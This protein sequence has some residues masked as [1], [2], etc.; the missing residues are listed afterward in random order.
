MTLYLKETYMIIW[1]KFFALIVSFALLLRVVLLIYRSSALSFL[2][3]KQ[4]GTETLKLS[5]MRYKLNS[6]TSE[7]NKLRICHE[8]ITSLENMLVLTTL[9]LVIVVVTL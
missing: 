5:G 7:T 6:E 8:C 4:Y 3:R 2:L 9:F 1:L